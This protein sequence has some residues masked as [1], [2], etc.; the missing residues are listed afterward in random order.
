MTTL[1]AILYIV[2]TPVYFAH[3]SMLCANCLDERLTPNDAATLH[4]VGLSITLYAVFWTVLNLLFVFVYC[5]VAAFI[6]WRKPDDR[7]T[8]LA[9][10][11]L[12]AMGA[13]FPDIP[14]AL[15]TAHSTWQAPVI[16]LDALG[17]PSLIIFLFLFPT[18]RFVP[19]YMRWVAGGSA[20][21]YILPAFFPISILNFTHLAHTLS[22]LVA[23]LV[24]GA[25]VFAQ[26]YRYRK[27][28]T[29]AERQQTKWVVF[30]LVIALLGFLLVSYLPLATLQFFFPGQQISFPISAFLIAS[31]YPLLLVIPLAIAIAILRYRLWDIDLIINRTLV[32]V[33]LTVGVVGAYA[34]VIVSLD[35]LL[36]T[37]SNFLISLFAAGV[38]A[39]LFQPLR[40]RLQR[41]VNRLLYGQRDE[42]YTVIA[43]LSQRLKETLAHDAVLST[44]TETVAQALKLPYVAIRWKQGETFELA[45]SYGSPVD[46]PLTLPLIYQSETIGQLQLAP[47]APGEAFTPAD[48]RLLD[49]LARQAGL[50][51]HAVQLATDLQRARELLVLAHEEERRRLRRDLHDGIGP[52]LASLSQRID[53]ATRLVHSDP[54]AAIALLSSLKA[55]VKS[56]IA[57]VRRVVYALRPPVLDELGLISA[58][59]EYALQPQE[60]NS[61]LIAVEAPDDLPPLP[62]AVEVAAYRI[63]L[64]AI[65]NVER[66]AHAQRCF[67]RLEVENERALCL[68]ISDDGCGLPDEYHAGVGVTSIHERVM[69]LGGACDIMRQATGGTCVSVRLPLTSELMGRK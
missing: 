55:Q 30:G 47:R 38:I 58:I 21:L 14:N 31:V 41:S 51:T 15:A 13:S 56:T 24:F 34:A 17:L 40:E 6:L 3:L 25:I 4:M 37:E 60:A 39:V 67:V 66:H 48:L 62:A 64:E 59:R 61:L 27:V 1:A 57:D 52:T 5:G 16:L 45:A 44:I 65:T 23:L 36:R 68:S 35:V 19:G 46:A 20:T 54:D 7:I 43:R 18:G 2:G 8:V 10:F 12:M 69:E 9:A 53:T 49:E 33:L 50:A 28:S 22:L 11:S 63:A 26:V 32:Y 42:P 29:L